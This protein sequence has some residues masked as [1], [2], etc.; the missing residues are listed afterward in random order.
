[1]TKICHVSDTHGWFHSVPEETDIIVHSGDFLPNRTFGIRAIEESYQP[2]WIE[3]NSE[4]LKRWAGK[5]PVLITHGNHDFINTVPYLRRIGIDAHLLD[6]TRHDQS[7]ISFYG[8]PY[9]PTFT[10]SWNYETSDLEIEARLE[11]ANIEGMQ[12]LVAH[13]PLFGILDRNQNGVRCGSKPM[14]KFLQDSSWVP[15]YYLCG[16][17]H[18]SA[19]RVGWSRRITVINSAC[20]QTVFEI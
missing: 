1:M 2:V 19:G 5:R 7:G 9:V 18:E 17:I 16:H 3:T 14:R 10:K 11:V 6:D 12:I 8:F 20:I 4:K 15:E 13:S